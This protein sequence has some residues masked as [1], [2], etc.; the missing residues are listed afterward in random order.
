MFELLTVKEHLEIFWDFKSTNPDQSKRRSEID[1]LIEDVGLD[2]RQNTLASQ[3]SG[4]NMRKLS[5]ALALVG[6][7]KLII[8]DEPTSSLDLSSRRKI[9][10]MLKQ[11]KKDRI[12]LLTTHCMDE[13]DILADRIAI[14]AKGRISCLGSPLFLK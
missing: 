14:M 10:S 5:A 6:G 1:K 7:S 4:G 2:D 9:W 13:A 11:Y 12:I 3:L 8:F